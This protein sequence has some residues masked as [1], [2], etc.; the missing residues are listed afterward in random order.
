MVGVEYMKK[1]VPAVNVK[2][3]KR[4]RRKYVYFISAV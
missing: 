1:L 4:V 2:E 3:R